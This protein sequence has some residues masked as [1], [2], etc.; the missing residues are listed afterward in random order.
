MPT[1]I[2]WSNEYSRELK[3]SIYS[4]YICPGGK[5]Y[6]SQDSI[7]TSERTLICPLPHAHL[8]LVLRTPLSRFYAGKKMVSIFDS[9]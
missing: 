8:R 5:K 9:D 3:R 2:F 6:I 7:R 1:V 4:T